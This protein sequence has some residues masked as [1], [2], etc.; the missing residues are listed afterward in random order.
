LSVNGEFRRILENL[1]AALRAAASPE[2][3]AAAAR[4]VLARERA[5]DDLADA[6]SMV[7]ATELPAF[8]QTAGEDPADI[9]DH[10]A[11]ICRAIVG[12]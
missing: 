3:D 8:P 9:F 4:L 10:L 2:A 5:D 11:A 1:L 7:L 6:A 12:S